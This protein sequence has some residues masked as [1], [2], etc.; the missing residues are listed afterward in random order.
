MTWYYLMQTMLSLPWYKEPLL[1][2]Q[3]SEIDFCYSC[4][5]A[6]QLKSFLAVFNSCTW[7]QSIYHP[8]TLFLHLLPILS[9]LS[10][11]SIM[12][13]NFSVSVSLLTIYHSEN[14]G[15]PSNYWQLLCSSLLA[16]RA[17]L[18]IS[19]QFGL[20][21]QVTNLDITAKNCHL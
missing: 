2:N 4:S 16:G 12:N 19:L 18:C 5:R 6:W 13:C 20:A 7:S 11:V 3:Q 9:W 15:T 8:L 21:H 17:Y 1:L 10:S 14:F